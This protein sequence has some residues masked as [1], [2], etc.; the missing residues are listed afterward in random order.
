M[1]LFRATKSELFL[2]KMEITLMPLVCLQV[3]ACQCA[4]VFSFPLVTRVKQH[5]KK[6]EKKI[7][8]KT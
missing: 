1:A 4:T 8:R 2:R 5:T 3:I 7:E 6:N